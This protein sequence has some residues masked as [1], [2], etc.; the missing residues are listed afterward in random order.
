MIDGCLSKPHS[1][2]LD[3]VEDA[4][5]DESK[6]QEKLI[7]VA[8]D[9]AGP[10]WRFGGSGQKVREGSRKV[11]PQMHARRAPG[12]PRRDDEGYGLN[13]TNARAANAVVL[14]VQRHF[15]ANIETNTSLRQYGPV[16][17]LRVTHCH[18]EDVFGGHVVSIVAHRLA[19]MRSCLR[20][21][22]ADTQRGRRGLGSIL[23]DLDNPAR[24][25]VVLERLA[26]IVPDIGHANEA[27][28]LVIND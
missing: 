18:P 17:A 25:D 27:V 20:R 1:R 28:L 10:G 12:I 19:A 9:Q 14:R 24:D 3:Q 21:R 8:L 11:V 22:C 6:L 15:N 23:H 5:L 4:V 16:N 2:L 7:L 26:L 13:D